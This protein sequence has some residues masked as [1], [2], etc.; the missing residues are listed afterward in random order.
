M[1][2]VTAKLEE[3]SINTPISLKKVDRKAVNR[4]VSEVNEIL[5]YFL[6]GEYK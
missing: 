1:E 3:G 2:E 5:N 4:V 6:N